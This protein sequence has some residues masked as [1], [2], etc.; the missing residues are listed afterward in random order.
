MET[1][2]KSFNDLKAEIG[3]LSRAL[4]K[5]RAVAAFPPKDKTILEIVNDVMPNHYLSDAVV[6]DAVAEL[7]Q[8]K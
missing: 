6:Q 7:E 5:I 8:D 2:S 1:F 4:E 3:M